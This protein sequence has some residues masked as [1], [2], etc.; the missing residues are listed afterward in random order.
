MDATGLI[1]EC[2][3]EAG[4][5]LRLQQALRDFANIMDM[6]FVQAATLLTFPP[7]VKLLPGRASLPMLGQSAAPI[8]ALWVF[9]HLANTVDGYYDTHTTMPP[10]DIIQSYQDVQGYWGYST[11]LFDGTRRLAPE[12]HLR[13]SGRCGP[14]NLRRVL[15]KQALPRP[16]GGIFVTL[17]FGESSQSILLPAGSLLLQ[18]LAEA[19][20]DPTAPT[21][22]VGHVQLHQDARLWH[23]WDLWVT[24]YGSGPDTTTLGLS[25]LAL[26]G[27]AFDLFA[28]LHNRPPLHCRAIDL[29]L[30][31][32][33]SFNGDPDQS[34]VFVF[35]LHNHHWTIVSMQSDHDTLHCQHYDGLAGTASAQ[36]AFAYCL[37]QATLSGQLLRFTSSRLITQL[38]PHTCGTVALL[39]LALCLGLHHICPQPQ[40]ARSSYSM[41]PLPATMQALSPSTGIS[42][43]QHP[44][45]SDMHHHL[46]LLDLCWRDQHAY[47]Q[48]PIGLGPGGDDQQLLDQLR[49]LLAEKGVLDD[50]ADERAHLALKMIG[51]NEVTTAL[52]GQG[53]KGIAFGGL[54]QLAPFL[55]EGKIISEAHS[56]CKLRFPATYIATAEPL[57]IQGSLISLGKGA[58]SRNIDHQHTMEVVST[59]TLRLTIYRD[60]WPHNWSVFQERPIRAL[61]EAV[62]VLQ[63]C[64]A[65]GCGTDCMKFHAPADE[66]LEVL[67][68]D[69]WSR[70]WLANN[71]KFC[72]PSEATS[73]SVLVRVP[74]CAE[75]SIQKASG[76]SGFYAEPRSHCGK[77]ADEAYGAI[78]LPGF[79][80]MDALH[81]LCI[82]DHA[83]C[84][85]RIHSKYGLRFSAEHHADA[86]S[87][88]RPTDTFVSSKI[89]SIYRIYPLPF[90]TQRSNLQHLLSK[91]SWDAKVLH[92][93][94]G[95]SEGAAW[96]VGSHLPPPSHVMQGSFGDAAITLVKHVSR[97]TPQALVLATPSTRQHIRG[98]NTSTGNISN[99]GQQ[100][101]ASNT[102]A[103]PADPWLVKDPWGGSQSSHNPDRLQ[104]LE[105]R[106][107]ADFAA[108]VQAHVN[109]HPSMEIDDSDQRQQDD[110]R[111][112]RMEVSIQELQRQNQRFDAFFGEIQATTCHQGNRIENLQ[113]QLEKQHKEVEFLRNDL[114]HEVA[115][116]KDGQNALQ[117][118]IGRG[119]ANMEALLEKRPRMG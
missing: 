78:W 46:V 82:V 114:R 30:G 24:T 22:S 75:R 97:V 42:T 37:D 72:A 11:Q 58:I 110:M 1:L 61:L 118:H 41:L 29:Q 76:A 12:A 21:L 111:M 77:L 7:G 3:V 18:F 89:H 14:Y 101:S 19:G 52:R 6:H 80:L 2:V 49:R 105:T 48:A 4:Y 53:K 50:R 51:H 87:H 90:G 62:P 25:S 106:L 119:F 117:D 59:Q 39:H 83:I 40:L 55:R 5:N 70:S 81:K 108:H 32:L 96:E 107:K 9:A 63:L 74:K 57:L 68:L 33:W 66:L 95:G 45:I 112:Q 94:G 104:Q 64:K 71:G 115:T 73:F 65:S 56:K 102:Q 69:I 44:T 31:P 27:G 17:H 99:G 86:F 36:A 113:A 47:H 35:L 79:N 103:A 116:L 15:K 23:S 91:W 13:P 92:A 67:L 34:E 85:C 93:A 88:L 60:D 16:D 54:Q 26:F 38:S 20:L 10:T 84:V 28:L 100:A 109:Q 43:D 98:G 8:Q